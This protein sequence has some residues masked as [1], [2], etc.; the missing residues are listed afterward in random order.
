MAV[1]NYNDQHGHLPPAV[2]YSEDGQ[3]LY[4]WRVLILP[5]I[6]QS[7]LYSQ[8]NLDEPWDSP[9]NIRL[10]DKM[11]KSYAV[12]TRKSNRVPPYHTICHVL[13]GPGTAFESQQQLRLEGDFPDGLSNTLLIVE[14]GEPVPWT[15]PDALIFDPDGPLPELRTIFKDD[16][17]VCMADG[18]VRFVRKSIS[19][20]TLRAAITRNG[21]DM[22][23]PDW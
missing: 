22:L 18:S 4:S 11:P 6:E 10:L 20:K 1:Q 8:F 7:D 14:A 3:P 2:V 16:F 12:P 23:G 13:V 5:Y 17:R 19:E 9:N 21:K 15:K